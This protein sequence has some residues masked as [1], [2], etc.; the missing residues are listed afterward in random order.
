MFKK[1]ELWV[2]LLLLPLFI[3]IIIG[4]GA[5][6]KEHYNGGLRY[7][8]LRTTAVFLAEIPSMIKKTLLTRGEFLEEYNISLT[9]AKDQ[10]FG[11]KKGFVFNNKK[12]I[13]LLLVLSRTD[14][15]TKSMIVE[16]IDLL[17]YKVIKTYKLHKNIIEISQNSNLD[18]YVLKENAVVR[19]PYISDDLSITFLTNNYVIMKVDK[20]QN[21]IWHN[22]EYI[23][24]HTFNYTKNQK[25][26]WTLACDNINRSGIDVQFV[27]NNYCDETAIKLDSS[28]GQIL[29]KIS[30]TK[31]FIN[32]N[33]H[34]LLFSGRINK[35]APDTMH[36]NDI[37]VIEKDTSYF[38]KGD[39]FISLAGQNMVLLID[40]KKRNIK[41]FTNKGLFKQHDVDIISESE[42]A[43][44]NN[45]SISI[46]EDGGHTQKN[47]EI[48]VYDFKNNTFSSPFDK[49]LHKYDVRTISQGLQEITSFGTLVE[50]QNYGRLLFLNQEELFFEYINRGDDGNVYQ[51][52]WSRLIK[53]ERKKNKLRRF[54]E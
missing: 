42:I 39:L 40:T 24:H 51:V 45:N 8:Y 3:F 48:T 53:E 10:R 4:F 29:E 26:I 16:L 7:P 9:K 2:F 17:S 11:N 23:F 5:I 47:N 14:F 43:I 32:Q 25:Y 28:N 1:I 30:L 54:L 12:P 6:L 44:F 41:W 13:D 35:P 46:R 33:M 50:E 31:L 52:H 20:D 21:T 22:D 37:E 38:S 19:S 49:I 34:N 15:K 36:A 27:T 18:N